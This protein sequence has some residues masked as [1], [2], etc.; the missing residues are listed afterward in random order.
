MYQ[1][2]LAAA[3]VGPRL[4]SREIRISITPMPRGVDSCPE[5]FLAED[6]PSTQHITLTFMSSLGEFILPIYQTRLVPMGYVH[7]PI[8]RNNKNN[9]MMQA[10]AKA[11]T[12][13]SH[14]EDADPNPR[15]NPPARHRMLSQGGGRAI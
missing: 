13:A 14:H 11:V 8:G 5:V 9:P 15:T 12:A 7:I 3:G 2:C 6:K 10:P 4:L 1:Y